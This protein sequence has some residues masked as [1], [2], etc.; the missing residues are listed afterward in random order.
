METLLKDGNGGHAETAIVEI[1]V[2]QRKEGP[3]SGGSELHCCG[4]HGRNRGERK[5]GLGHFSVVRIF[6]LND[7]DKR[8]LFEGEAWRKDLS[9]LLPKIQDIYTDASTNGGLA[10]LYRQYIFLIQRA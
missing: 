8:S 4:S 7:K 6:F 10:K 9:D 1:A 2:D 5:G 3:A